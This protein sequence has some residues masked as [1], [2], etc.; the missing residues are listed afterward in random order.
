MKERM[1]NKSHER[2]QQGKDAPEFLFPLSLA[3]FRPSTLYVWYVY[4]RGSTQLKL[5]NFVLYSSIHCAY[6]SV[7]NTSV[8]F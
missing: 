8:L 3:I 7:L 4:G 1:A 5:W 2:S 6:D